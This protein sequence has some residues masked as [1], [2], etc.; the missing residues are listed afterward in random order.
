[1]PNHL[2]SWVLPMYMYFQKS[3][4]LRHSCFGTRPHFGPKLR[5][6]WCT[7]FAAF[8]DSWWLFSTATVSILNAHKNTRAHTKRFSA[9]RSHCPGK[10]LQRFAGKGWS[11][12]GCL[13]SDL[14]NRT[15]A[16][17]RAELWLSWDGNTYRIQWI[18]TKNIHYI[19]CVQKEGHFIN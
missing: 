13:T 15:V 2:L 3:A 17:S 14:S 16:P 8:R 6:W 5:R 12:R 18:D 11:A 10:K 7:V 1:M 9:N 4:S 19:I